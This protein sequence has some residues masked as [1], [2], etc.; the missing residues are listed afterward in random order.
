[1]VCLCLW[2]GCECLVSSLLFWSGLL[3]LGQ[4]GRFFHCHWKQKEET[5]ED[6]SQQLHNISKWNG[7]DIDWS[8]DLVDLNMLGLLMSDIITYIWMT[9][10]GMTGRAAGHEISDTIK[11]LIHQIPNKKYCICD[12][13]IDDRNPVSGSLMIELTRSKFATEKVHL[14]LHR[15]ILSAIWPKRKLVSSRC[16]FE[17]D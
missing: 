5:N 6:N 16:V 7:V 10:L 17:L 14:S 3:E 15:M 8:V 11:N 1:M 4:S 12:M 2:Y 9:V 13:A